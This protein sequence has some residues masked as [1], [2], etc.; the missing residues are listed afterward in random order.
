M[1]VRTL[2][3]RSL[4][5]AIHAAA[6]TL[7]LAGAAPALLAAEAPAASS[8]RS[9]DIAPGPLGRTLSAF[10]SDNGV[11]LAFD[12]ALTEG[13]RS[14]ALRGRYAPVEALHRLLLG[15]GLELQQRSD[16]S[17]TLVP[18]ATDG[19]LELQSSLITAQAAGAETLPAEYAGGQVARGARLGMLGNADVMDAPFSITSYTAR[20]IEQQQARSVADL[21]QANDPSVRVVGGRGDLVDSYTIR[22]FSVQNADVAFNGLYGL[23][24]FWRVPIEFAERVEVLKGPNALLGGISPGGSVGGTIN[25]VPKRADDQPLTRVSVDWTQRSQL[26]THLDIGRRFGENNAFGVRFNGVYRNGDTAVDHQSR[27]FPMLSLGLDF[28]GERLRLSS[29]LLYQKES[30]EG[31]VRPLLTGPGTTHIP[32]APDSK[33]RFGLRDSYLD[34]EDYSMV[35]RGEYDLAD[36]LTAFASIGGRQSNYETIAANSILIGNQGDIVN[37]LARQR[38]DRRTYSAEVGLRGNFDTGPL[39]HDWTLSANRLHERLGMVYAFTGMQP[40]NLY[41]TSPHTPLP[42]FSSL[43]GSIPK[44]NETDL[45]G[46]ALADRLSFLEDR[47]QVTLG[48][49]RQQIESRNYD[50]TSGAR[51]SHDKRH[52]WT[53]MASVLVKP[54]Q[55]LSLYANYIQGLSQGE[56]APMTA[57]NAG[58]VLAPYKAEQYEIGAKY[59]LG[60]FTT[61]LALFEI[62]KPNAYTDASNVF[63]ADGEQRNRGVELSLY[64]EPLDGVRVMAGATYIKPEQNKTG[65]P[66][67]EGK[68]A[69]G[70]ARRQANLGVSW[71]TPFV[72]GLTLDSR[73][74]YTGSAY[75]DSANALAVPHWNRVDLGAAYAFQVAGKPLVARANLENA[76]GKDYW[77]AA[78]G[79]LSISS[80]RTLS[81]FPH[82]GLLSPPHHNQKPPMTSQ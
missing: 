3:P 58:Q 14:A 80:P 62:R 78:N 82:G 37:S 8:A 25:L 64:G 13:R 33:T 26:G 70:V 59:D 20:T 50:Q 39:R 66:A 11:S 55:D 46:V 22:G 18:A 76:L 10:A 72:D 56:A 9:Y 29:D 32:H 75:L 2:R 77:T 30:L 60:G 42:D 1:P 12:P 68:D 41:Q 47:V 36:N 38:G 73:W 23:L 53:P 43:D 79:Y 48:V 71:D 21:L 81:L 31:V 63:R 28:R 7:A 45:G 19:A 52:V 65:D 15:S 24:P 6:M 51:T 69:P 4:S 49:R 57:A 74:I 40:G 34:Q 17:Y 67:S 27:E 16:G 5:L 44:T 35:N 54:L 61:T